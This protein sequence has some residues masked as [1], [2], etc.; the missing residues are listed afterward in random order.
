MANFDYEAAKK[1]GASDEKIAEFLSNKYDFDLDKAK[2]EGVSVDKINH[3]LSYREDDSSK[4]PSSFIDKFKPTEAQL[5]E[6]EERP[7]NGPMDTN[8]LKTSSKGD[9]ERTIWQ[10]AKD[11]FKEDK[12]GEAMALQR[13]TGG[14]GGSALYSAEAKTVAKWTL[15]QGALEGIGKVFEPVLGAAK[16]SKFVPKTLQAF[17]RLTQA[18]ISGTTASAIDSL[19]ENGELPSPGEMLEHGV[20]WT[21]I[22]AALQAA[23]ITY[24]GGK[25]VYDFGKAINNIAKKDGVPV[26][27]VLDN[28][29][30]ATKNYL[31]Q[32]FGRNIKSP[33]DIL[34]ADVE[35][36]AEKVKEIENRMF[37]SSPQKTQEPQSAPQEPIQET[38]HEEPLQQQ[39]YAPKEQMITAPDKFLKSDFEIAQGI[40]QA[41][42]PLNKEKE[43]VVVSPSSISSLFA[44]VKMELDSISPARV[45]KPN[46]IGRDAERIVQKVSDEIYR[47]NSRLWDE[48]EDLA[49]HEVF[50]RRDLAE[51]LHSIIEE[52][53]SK[54][55]EGETRLQS[56]AEKLLEKLERRRGQK[57]QYLAMSNAQLIKEIKEAR[58]GYN[59]RLSGGVPGHRI[60]E[61]INF[62]EQELI[63][64]SS[65]QSRNALLRAREASKNW[66]IR[67]KDPSVLPF[68]DRNLSTPQESY[69]RL[70]NPDTYSILSDI[71]ERDPKG[72]ELLK[73][74]QRNM[75]EKSI[76][77]YL[78]RPQSFN[79]IKYERDISKLE[80]IIPDYILGPI[81]EKIYNNYVQTMNK[82]SKEKNEFSFSHISEAQVPSKLGTI[83]GLRK[84]KEELSKVPGG[85]EKY[86]EYAGT[87]GIELLFG[88]QM[89]VPANSDRIKKM[90]NDRNGR[91]YIKETLGED[92]VKVLD[93]LV[94]KNQLEKRLLEI[95]ESPTLSSLVKNPDIIIKG[96]KL[97]WSILKGNPISI[98]QHANSLKNKVSKHMKKEE[99]TPPSS[100]DIQIQ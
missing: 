94:K 56:H 86:E 69:S 31:G 64:T 32:K 18:G 3:F 40:Q 17:A 78:L 85:K 19:I 4:G 29:W 68:R 28:L 39:E 37:G 35:V 59:Y 26:T 45:V 62:V 24:R 51:N 6:E 96:T 34:P 22:D 91:P 63:R 97:L 38:Q 14:F 1:A 55:M 8:F 79:P 42:S 2:K 67:F 61:F 46:L 95:K 10:R 30:Q 70:M 47:E 9:D 25:N 23:H 50:N 84:L 48:A 81:G 7:L 75:L 33:A 80:E 98:L 93:E 90:L 16:A 36:M 43:G 82:P 13:K 100:P 65:P 41:L 72:R 54:P 53:P 99:A 88:G 49:S 60:N 58:K 87:M 20:M 27:E 21:A 11:Y 76:E 66:A 5:K 74:T 52:S 83:E 15:E 77:P 44:P 73:W 71:L 57:V 92:T 89:D 12:F